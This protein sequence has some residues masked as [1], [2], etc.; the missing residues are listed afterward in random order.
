MAQISNYKCFCV[1]F[2][3]V[4][5][6]VGCLPEQRNCATVSLDHEIGFEKNDLSSFNC[7]IKQIPIK[8]SK[9]Q[10]QEEQE[11]NNNKDLYARQAV[12]DRV[13]SDALL[14]AD[15]SILNSSFKLQVSKV[16]QVMNDFNRPLIDLR[17]SGD[18]SQVDFELLVARWSLNLVFT[19]EEL[20]DDHQLVVL[21]NSTNSVIAT[22][23]SKF[24]HW[25]VSIS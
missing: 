1:I 20:G 13:E 21:Y 24:Y 23:A 5:A 12:V 7:K 15:E 6:L 11:N 3:I 16:C 17:S 4:L 18:L 19:N 14:L 25:G 22:K 2:A 10:E 8:N 9:E